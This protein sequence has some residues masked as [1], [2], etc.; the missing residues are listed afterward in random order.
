MGG[1][2]ACTCTIVWPWSCCG[3]HQQRGM[4]R[5][6][7]PGQTDPRHRLSGSRVFNKLQRVQT[8]DS[9]F[10]IAVRSADDVQL[11]CLHSGVAYFVVYMHKS[12][13][14]DS[15]ASAPNPIQSVPRFP[16]LGDCTLG[17]KVRSAQVRSQRLEHL[18]APLTEHQQA[19][20]VDS[21]GGAEPQ[22]L[23]ASSGSGGRRQCPPRLQHPVWFGK[24]VVGQ[25][26]THAMH[27]T[28]T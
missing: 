27:R 13:R 17:H 19:A 14:P 22:S 7:W 9:Y 16:V 10:C 25:S 26:C 15:W 2:C 12:V 23:R 18:P 6:P 24:P 1:A 3:W 20:A 28:H 21:L 4:M 11:C 8:Y 5:G